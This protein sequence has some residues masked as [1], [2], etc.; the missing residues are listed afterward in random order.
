MIGLKL[1]TQMILQIPIIL[2]RQ[3]N[4]KTQENLPQRKFL[5]RKKSSKQSKQKSIKLSTQKRMF[6]KFV[7]SI[8][9]Q[10]SPTS[11]TTIEFI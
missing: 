2:N 8:T 3:R 6:A 5:H 9:R 10:R 7:E 1:H 11:I 4:Q